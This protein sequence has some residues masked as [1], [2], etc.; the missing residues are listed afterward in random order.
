MVE[1]AGFLSTVS[2]IAKA[3]QLID[4]LIRSRRGH[5][6]MLLIEMKQNLSTITLFTERGAPI[7]RVIL[8]LR[9]EKLK[10]LLA[11]NFNFN[12]IQK[13]KVTLETTGNVPFYT[14]YIGWT[15]DKLFENIYLKITDLQAVVNIDPENP[16]IRKSVRLINIL[17]LI[18]LLLVHIH[19]HGQ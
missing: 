8:A 9:T 15:T 2:N 16:N 10:E 12:S 18:K 17:K 4:D 11:S 14:P 5:K 13:S 3:I 1:I 6:R 7:D 19:G